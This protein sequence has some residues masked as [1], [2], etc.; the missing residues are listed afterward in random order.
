MRTV[1]SGRVAVVRALGPFSPRTP[2][3]Q[4]A[5][6][7]ARSPPCG[8]AGKG[9]AAGAAA[10][11]EVCEAVI[12]AAKE[13][14][15]IVAAAAG[16]SNAPRRVWQLAD[17][18]VSPRGGG[19]AMRTVPGGRVAVVRALSPRTPDEQRAG[20]AARSP[21]GG[22][23]G[24]GE[25][26]AAARVEVFE[27]VIAAALAG[28][29]ARANED[30]ELKKS[31][32][33]FFCGDDDTAGQGGSSRRL[34][35]G[36]WRDAFSEVCEAFGVGSCGR[37]ASRRCRL[38]RRTAANAR[39]RR[40]ATSL[41][42]VEECPQQ[43]RRTASTAVL[44]SSCRDW[45]S[46]TRSCASLTS[47]PSR[48]CTRRGSLRNLREE[49]VR[50]NRTLSREVELRA[51]RGLQ[52]APFLHDL[53]QQFDG[54]AARIERSEKTLMDGYA[55]AYLKARNEEW[56]L[57]EY[58]QVVHELNEEVG[59]LE[60][61]SSE[62]LGLLH[63][64]S[65]AE[66]TLS[67]RE[68]TLESVA[69]ELSLARHMVIDASGCT[70][71]MR[72]C[73]RVV[74]SVG[75][76]RK[77]SIRGGAQDEGLAFYAAFAQREANILTSLADA[78]GCED[79][80]AM[81]S[82]AV[83]KEAECFDK[84]MGSHT[85]NHRKWQEWQ[86]SNKSILQQQI[87]KALSALTPRTLHG[88]VSSVVYPPAAAAVVEAAKAVA[89][90]LD[91]ERLER[92][93][94]D[95]RSFVADYLFLSLQAFV[96]EAVTKVQGD[97]AAEKLA[98]AGSIGF[99]R[100]LARAR[101][102]LV[103]RDVEG[104]RAAWYQVARFSVSLADTWTHVA[105]AAETIR[106]L[107]ASDCSWS[108]VTMDGATPCDETLSRCARP[109][110]PVCSPKPQK[111]ML[112]LETPTE[113]R[114]VS[115][116]ESTSPD[117]SKW[118]VSS[119]ES[120][121]RPKGTSTFALT[122]ASSFWMPC[123]LPDTTNDEPG[124][125][126]NVSA[127]S[128]R[129]HRP[130]TPPPPQ[131]LAVFNSVQE[132]ATLLVKSQRLGSI[133]ESL[134]SCTIAGYTAQGVSSR[135]PLPSSGSV[136]SALARA[137]DSVVSECDRSGRYGSGISPRQEIAMA[138]QRFRRMGH[139]GKSGL[140]GP[141]MRS[142]GRTALSFSRQ[143]NLATGSKCYSQPSQ[144]VSQGVHSAGQT[145]R[146]GR[147]SVDS[148]G[149]SHPPSIG[150]YFS[151]PHS[152]ASPASLGEDGAEQTDEASHHT[153]PINSE[154]PAYHPPQALQLLRVVDTEFVAAELASLESVVGGFEEAALSTDPGRMVSARE[155]FESF[156]RDRASR[157]LAATV[158][159]VDADLAEEQPAR[160]LDFLQQLHSDVRS[161]APTHQNTPAIYKFAHQLVHRSAAS[162]CTSNL[163][164]RLEADMRR[165]LNPRLEGSA[166]SILERLD[167]HECQGGL[168]R[169]FIALRDEYVQLL[170]ENVRES[171]QTIRDS[172]DDWEA[173]PGRESGSEAILD[174]F[175]QRLHDAAIAGNAAGAD[176][177]ERDWA[178]FQRLSE[179]ARGL[180]AAI[181]AALAHE[182][183]TEVEKTV[184]T[185]LPDTLAAAVA[186]ADDKR[187]EGVAQRLNAFQRQRLAD[188][189][190]GLVD[191]LEASMSG[192]ESMHDRAALMKLHTSA[193][194]LSKCPTEQGI[195]ELDVASRRLFGVL[196]SAR[197]LRAVC[198]ELLA[199]FSTP[200]ARAKDTLRADVSCI[201]RRSA[202]ACEDQQA[203]CTVTTDA[204]ALH[205]CLDD[206]L[207]LREHGSF[208]A[209]SVLTD[210]EA[211]QLAMSAGA[212]RKSGHSE[213]GVADQFISPPPA[214]RSSLRSPKGEITSMPI[215]ELRE[216]VEEL[217][218]NLNRGVA[219]GECKSFQAMDETA[220]ALAERRWA[221]AAS[222]A[223]GMLSQLADAYGGCEAKSA[224]VRCMASCIRCLPGV[225][226]SEADADFAQRRLPADT[227]CAEQAP[228]PCGLWE[229]EPAASLR[230][231]PPG[232]RASPQAPNAPAATDPCAASGCAVS[233]LGHD[234]SK[235]A[236]LPGPGT[237]SDP[238]EA[239]AI[240]PEGAF[241][242]VAES[243]FLSVS[244]GNSHLLDE[245]V[246][247]NVFVST[248]D[249]E[250]PVVADKPLHDEP[251]PATDT[252]PG[253]DG[254][255]AARTREEAGAVQSPLVTDTRVGSA[256]TTF[257]SP[258]GLLSGKAGSS[259]HLVAD[260]AVS[261]KELRIDAGVEAAFPR[262]DSEVNQL[263]E[264]IAVLG[265]EHATAG[266][267]SRSA[268]DLRLL[269]TRRCH[270]RRKLLQNE[271]NG[272]RNAMLIEFG[273]RGQE[274]DSKQSRLDMMVTALN[275]RDTSEGAMDIVARELDTLRAEV[276]DSRRKSLK[277]RV[278]DEMQN[279]CSVAAGKLLVDIQDLLL[280]ASVDQADVDDAE[281]NLN[282]CKSA[283]IVQTMV[284]DQLQRS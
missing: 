221:P 15:N 240:W 113:V 5:G 85:E 82:G 258:K 279:P 78:D 114:T 93:A 14:G 141:D 175:R 267:I 24:K 148:W 21:P 260:A 151:K 58:R 231:A 254:T 180:R 215:H 256:T 209:P 123:K 225:A 195:E 48:R 110:I 12:A 102:C 17:G 6:T 10:R 4:Q 32:S 70:E 276:R 155:S 167:V 132:E 119:L 27:A 270:R 80:L 44:P 211:T 42:A 237:G 81:S 140:S 204:A 201:L 222:V 250:D 135:P 46:S 77:Q 18:R 150:T 190:A 61:G 208:R 202:S 134:K 145:E 212:F 54:I 100:T 198:T 246:A 184:L 233:F 171:A 55:G 97:S 138:Q 239:A 149:I 118:V 236:A 99:R 188:K 161:L 87:F 95:T 186:A 57:T 47:A 74:Q 92:F 105:S 257:T 122:Q 16:N 259:T 282:E 39:P 280:S 20:T 51:E 181:A 112:P 255:K 60:R 158:A 206:A 203:S 153:S 168:P 235:D 243:S 103:E 213:D 107:K 72:S 248:Y 165:G 156:V 245:A 200:Q 262:T 75:S 11:V 278:D 1:P 64:K 63:K 117:A 30:Q 23:A 37:P 35:E 125:E 13:G 142:S 128:P 194:V 268:T 45:L 86:I 191:R 252:T 219:K 59:K 162:K 143:L 253:V 131:T 164:A 67:Q 69:C 177:V 7:A 230:P 50:L 214:V 104:L 3:E 269:K 261:V 91:R 49:A 234:P 28:E 8:G 144:G 53:V 264:V 154:R 96:D 43:P 173:A 66:I 2:H 121:Q 94:E 120:S 226:F 41:A 224:A 83:L 217:I 271:V 238:P 275:F 52:P 283:R 73:L 277:T 263:K 98:R 185:R 160:Y 251:R 146:S 106:V 179:K 109:P 25:A 169:G 65:E 174:A 229:P 152:D 178:A 133:E 220:G 31:G 182:G 205:F 34:S 88:D 101:A 115:T 192:C 216:V 163:R 111:G 176:A 241:D 272:F 137:L 76:V 244:L 170:R 129:A 242:E 207:F 193:V 139:S 40:S 157:V 136:E 223:I 127:W 89:G 281:L 227:S 172:M 26:A 147:V 183:L 266:D 38:R 56:C 232:L 33:L 218:E 199:S 187:V 228:P 196:V 29:D 197:R 274:S 189:A 62:L 108:A 79:S 265:N 210:A 19:G 116:S 159:K 273:S 284:D 84:E 71:G 130:T 166:R 247:S 249:A 126:D 9:E 68:L 124:N 22:G 36:D 90:K